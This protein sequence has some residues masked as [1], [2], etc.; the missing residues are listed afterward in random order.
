[1]VAV[2]KA[3]PM[4]VE[5]VSREIRNVEEGRA[6]LRAAASRVGDAAQGERALKRVRIA[7]DRVVGSAEIL[8]PTPAPAS[9]T[10]SAEAASSSSSCLRLQPKCMIK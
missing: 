7:E 2:H 3:T 5:F 6:R 1:M 9:S 4:N 10:L 8:E